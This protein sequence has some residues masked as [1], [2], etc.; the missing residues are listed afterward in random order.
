MLVL[1]LVQAQ[2]EAPLVVHT[3]HNERSFLKLCAQPG[4][5]PPPLL[6]MTG[7]CPPLPCLA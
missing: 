7:D 2:D 5:P 3:F 4:S 1:V 6:G